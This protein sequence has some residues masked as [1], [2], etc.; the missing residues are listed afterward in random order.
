MIA[1]S[2]FCCGLC[3]GI[4]NLALGI[5]ALMENNKIDGFYRSGNYEAAQAASDKAGKYVKIGFIVFGV[6]LVLEIIFYIVYFI[7]AA[8]S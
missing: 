5:M 1:V 2:V 7:V 6:G 4:V 8:N 3:A